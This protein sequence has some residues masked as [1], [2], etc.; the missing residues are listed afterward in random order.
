VPA[1]NEAAAGTPTSLRDALNKHRADPICS[2]CHSRMDPL[3]FGLENYDAIGRWR[4]EDNKA[5]IQVGGTLPNGVEFSTPAQLRGL[6]A[7]ELPEFTRN[8]TEKM[9][10]YAM[11][12]GTQS[13]DR[14]L[15]RDIVNK[16]KKS[17]YRF[18]TLI[19]EIVRSLPF[20]AR[21]GQ[22]KNTLEVASK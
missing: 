7:Q 4:T 3:G 1:L 5:P 17:D 13:Y 21:R 11:G 9:L 19:Q 15:I 14:L 22:A 12:R 2:S 8:L 6:L 20:Q 16:M 10:I 18:Q